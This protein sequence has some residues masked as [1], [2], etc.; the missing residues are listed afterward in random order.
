MDISWYQVAD[1]A[2]FV[3]LPLCSGLIAI[4]ISLAVLASY[5]G[6]L[7]KAWKS[8][9]AIISSITVGFSLF[10]VVLIVIISVIKSS[11]L[12][13]NYLDASI[14]RDRAKDFSLQLRPEF[15]K[16]LDAVDELHEPEGPFLE[17]FG[18]LHSAASPH[19][20][21]YDQILDYNQHVLLKIFLLECYSL[22]ISGTVLTTEL[23]GYPV[24]S[25][26]AKSAIRYAEDNSEIAE[27][28]CRIASSI[29]LNGFE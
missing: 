8:Y 18:A 28:G 17:N 16:I 19:G 10:P 11:V 27:P 4:V 1:P 24:Y 22:S 21:K 3:I 29:A 7:S 26:E 15:Q 13:I 5:S 20:I 2:L 14:H 25:S 9:T 23:S 6:S 12:E